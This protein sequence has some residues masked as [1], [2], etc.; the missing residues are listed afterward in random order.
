MTDPTEHTVIDPIERA[1]HDAM[2]Y[3]TGLSVPDR[4]STAEAAE[5]FESLA[6][7]CQVRADDIR[8]EMHSTDTEA[9]AIEETEP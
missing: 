7:Q 1:V 3:L 9:A 2:E 6:E 4:M 8:K 5:F